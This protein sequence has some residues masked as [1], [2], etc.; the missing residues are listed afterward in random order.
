M[1]QSCWE[2]KNEKALVLPKALVRAGGE[3]GGIVFVGENKRKKTMIF[4]TSGTGPGERENQGR[5][6]TGPPK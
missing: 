5:I 1:G 6:V 2:K 3:K 4:A